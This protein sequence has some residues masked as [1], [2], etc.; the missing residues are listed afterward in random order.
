MKQLFI[1]SILVLIFLVSTYF[2]FEFGSGIVTTGSGF[3]RPGYTG[4]AIGFSLIA[5]ASLLGFVYFE[6]NYRKSDQSDS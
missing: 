4:G 5:S 1:K 6:C 2:V 3:S